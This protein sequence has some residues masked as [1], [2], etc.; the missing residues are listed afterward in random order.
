MG[1]VSDSVCVCESVC[2]W[3]LSVVSGPIKLK[4]VGEIDDTH[5]SILLKIHND[6]FHDKN[7][8]EK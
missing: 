1:R 5:I 7:A 3:F 6:S 8:S 4:F 2:L